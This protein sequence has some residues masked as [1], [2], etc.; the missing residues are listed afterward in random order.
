[1]AI[2]AKQS[3]SY[4]V[5]SGGDV[6]T[7]GWDEDGTSY[8]NVGRTTFYGFRLRVNSAKLLTDQLRTRLFVSVS[9]RGG[10]IVAS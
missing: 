9:W 7:Q 5:Q 1:M 6:E 3:P 2:K 8:L 4:R 10:R